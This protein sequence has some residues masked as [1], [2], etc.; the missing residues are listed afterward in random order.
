MSAFADS[1][2]ANSMGASNVVRAMDSNLMKRLRDSIYGQLLV[3]RTISAAD[4]ALAFSMPDFKSI[5]HENF[6]S[7]PI[8]ADLIIRRYSCQNALKSYLIK[9]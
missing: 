8:T 2:Y 1:G 3:L 4:A 5:R 6:Y 9:H 7:D